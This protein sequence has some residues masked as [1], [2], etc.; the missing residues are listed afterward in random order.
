MKR[1]TI[2]DIA[3][4]LTISV[5]TVSRALTNDKNIRSETRDRVIAAAEALGYRP[6][7]VA[8][9]LKYGRSGTVGVLVPEMITPFAS[10][11]IG[12]IQHALHSC[13]IKI[14]IADSHES[15]QIE[16]ENIA[17]MEKFMVDGIIVCLSDY[18]ENRDEYLRLQRAG[19]P[20]VFSDRIPHGMEVSQVIVDDYYKSFFLIEHLIRAG[21]KHIAHIHGPASVYNSLERYKGYRDALHKFNIELSQ[22]LI[23]KSGLGFDDGALA[24]EELMNRGVKIDAIFAFT[25]TLAIGAMNKLREMGVAMPD[26]IAITSFSGTQLS[27]LVTPQLTTIEPPLHQMGIEA[28][29]LILERIEDPHS[30]VRSIV[31]DATMQ[32]RAS[33]E[34]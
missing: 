15:W 26:D 25:D 34:G 17:T 1:T 2:K 27:K 16:R 5:S 8:T 4:Y 3:N 30:P 31:L 19:M 24:A 18:K 7:P 10:Q 21:R 29:N 12:G 32:F 33:S 28:A 22:D 23:I 14:I 13:G 20:M 11:I 6:N 9:N